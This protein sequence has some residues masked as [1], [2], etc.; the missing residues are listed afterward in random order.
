VIKI[1]FRESSATPDRLG[2]S[3]GVSK[4]KPGGTSECT[5]EKLSNGKRLSPS[6]ECGWPG[7]L[8]LPGQNDDQM[9]YQTIDQL[10][11]LTAFK[12]S[13]NKIVT[14]I[15]LS[16][17]A[18][19]QNDDLSSRNGSKTAWSPFASEEPGKRR[20]FPGTEKSRWIRPRPFQL[21]MVS[22]R[23]GRIIFWLSSCYANLSCR[24]FH[25]KC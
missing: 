12:N 11:R 1:S 7:F 3:V 23:R 25:C 16:A 13:G 15:S 4:T 9:F 17:D 6:M 19:G 10:S 8:R 21:F 20:R 18:I 22:A 24:Y 14:K 5:E 2:K